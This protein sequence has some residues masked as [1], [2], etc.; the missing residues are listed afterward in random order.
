MKGGER[1]RVREGKKGGG[2][3]REGERF[4]VKKRRWNCVRKGT[5]A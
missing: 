4:K 3:E 2:R 1:E 5:D